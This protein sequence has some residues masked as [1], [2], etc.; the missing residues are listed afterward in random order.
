MYIPS[1]LSPPQPPQ[2][3][4]PSPT[5]PAILAIRAMSTINSYTAPSPTPTVS[6][7]SSSTPSPQDAFREQF[8]RPGDVMS[9][10]LLLGGDV[11]QRALAQL[12]GGPITPVAFSFGW[13]TYAIS[14]LLAAVGINKLL[15]P[16]DATCS[17]VNSRSKYP[18]QNN[19]WILGRIMRDYEFWRDD[20]IAEEETKILKAEEERRSALSEEDREKLKGPPRIALSI[21]VYE[22]ST[23]KDKVAGKPDNDWI[24]YTGILCAFVQLGIA[25]IP[26]GLW[27]DWSILLTT[28]C[29]IVLAFAS[30]ALPQW[31]AEKWSC[32]KDSDKIV[33][34]TAGNGTKHVFVVVGNGV[35]LD[36]ED[37]AGGM[38]T[39]R[40]ETRPLTAALAALWVVLLIA[41]SGLKE[42]PW[43]LLAVGV[44]GMVQ[45]VVVCGAARKPAAFGVHLEYKGAIARCKVMKALQDLEDMYPHVGKS[46]VDTFFPGGGLWPDEVKFWEEAEVK[47]KEADKRKKEEDKRRKAEHKLAKKQA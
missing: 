37:L 23:N 18:R 5:S 1:P 38:G 29:G 3:P 34:L 21:A 14:A 24:Y 41:V 19:S 39:P 36:L 40:P 28:A 16:P 12:A 27:G 30:G 42:N 17:V 43:F 8:T 46:L 31:K 9:V 22:A 35:G 33:S 20:R 7:A 26:W 47:A 13:V 4:E 44:I 10:L 6:L 11:I 15:P 45:N 2:P 25:A 32:R